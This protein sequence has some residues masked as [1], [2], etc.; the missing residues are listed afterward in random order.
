MMVGIAHLRLINETGANRAI[1][2]LSIISIVITL[3]VQ[4]V[5]TLSQEPATRSPSLSSWRC[6][7]MRTRSGDSFRRSGQEMESTASLIWA[8]PQ[9]SNRG[10]FPPRFADISPSTIRPGITTLDRCE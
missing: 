3:L 6:R 2:Y 4:S 9:T 5:E 7:S 10:Y 1:I 8:K